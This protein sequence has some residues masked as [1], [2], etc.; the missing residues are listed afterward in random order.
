VKI[1]ANKAY[2]LK[3]QN[4]FQ[5][6]LAVLVIKW[7]TLNITSQLA[8]LTCSVFEW[9]NFVFSLAQKIRFQQVQRIF[10]TRTA[11]FCHILKNKIKLPDLCPIVN[12]GG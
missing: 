3:N 8:S 12:H 1:S 4:E 11:L 6:F 2:N 5:N 9:Q 10:V 7:F